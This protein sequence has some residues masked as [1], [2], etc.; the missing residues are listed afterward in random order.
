[1]YMRKISLAAIILILSIPIS[2]NKSFDAG[3]T[4]SKKMAGGWWVTFTQNGADIFGLGTFFLTTYND[5]AGDDSIWVDD[6]GHSWNFKCKAKADYSKL[7]F[8]LPGGQNVYYADTVFLAN[9]KVL[10]GG[11]K[12]RAGN[13]TDSIYMEAKFSDDPSGATYI[14]SGTA[15]TGFIEDDY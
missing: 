7:I 9:G 8:T 5:A 6:L 14:I 1:M 15:R 2:C 11:G 10:P 3:N 4:V 13:K 12:S